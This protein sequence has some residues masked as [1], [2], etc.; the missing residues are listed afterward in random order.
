MPAV[1][2]VA[3]KSFVVRTDTVDTVYAS[4]VN[5]LQ[6]EVASIEATLGVNPQSWAG[7]PIY[8]AGGV[9]PSAALATTT[10]MQAATY[11]SVADRLTAIQTQVANLT[12]VAN[13]WAYP[14]NA[15]QQPAA[16]VQCPGQMMAPGFQ[17]WQ[18]ILWGGAS[19]DSNG[20]FQGGADLLC[21]QSGW[22]VVSI[23]II[24]AIA[25]VT[26]I[27]HAMARLMV[28]GTEVAGA[29][30]QVQPG[31]VDAHR[32]NVSWSGAWTAGQ[33]IQAHFVQAPA[34]ANNDQ[35]LISASISLT[36]QRPVN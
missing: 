3:V 12:Q 24:S 2:P 20:M 30:S 18:P 35:V 36:Y 10:P 14:V 7:V 22:Y 16:S 8:P 32:I 29:G 33:T 6:Y 28:S 34:D 5:D 15:P 9:P 25:P 19:Y 1:Y 11:A 17:N 13:A 4:N 31:V 26:G 23:S 21:P 27:H